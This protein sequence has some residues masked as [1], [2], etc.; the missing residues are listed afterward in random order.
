MPSRTPG[1]CTSSSGRLRAAALVILLGGPSRDQRAGLA[2]P[3]AG[4]EGVK[5]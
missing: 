3:G 5:P 2:R 4:V 1:L